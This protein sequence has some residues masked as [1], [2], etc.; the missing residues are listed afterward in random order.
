MLASGVEFWRGT[1]DIVLVE[2]AGGLMSPLGDSLYNID[3]AARLGYPL[4]IVAANELGVI[5]AALQTI[6]TAKRAPL[7]CPS[8]A[9]SSTN[10]RPATTTPAPP[11]T[12]KTSPPAAPSRCSRISPSA[13][14]SLDPPV[15]WSPLAATR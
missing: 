3:L 10:P 13:T 7:A 2:G 1:S 4:V 9:S 14:T 8:R 5:N 12:P 15:D 11:P 6:I